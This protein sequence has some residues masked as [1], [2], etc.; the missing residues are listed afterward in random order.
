MQSQRRNMPVEHSLHRPTTAGM[1]AGGEVSDREA[2][3]SDCAYVINLE[4]QNDSLGFN[5]LTEEHRT[6]VC[7]AEL[8]LSEPD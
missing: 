5:C 1:R 7:A 8:H 3:K 6:L 4:G 2:G